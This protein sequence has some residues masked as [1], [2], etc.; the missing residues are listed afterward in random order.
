MSTKI[1][2]IGGTGRIGSKVVERLRGH[3]YEVVAAAPQTGVNTV[4][5]EGVAEA[6]KGAAVVVDVSNSPSFEENEALAF[7]PGLDGEP[8]SPGSEGRVGHLVALSVVG[9]DRMQHIP[10]FRAKIVVE[11]MLKVAPIPYSIVRATQF[12]EFVDMIAD[13]ATEG[14]VVRLPPVAF[15]PMAAEDVAK[16]V[17][18][19]AAGP[20]VNGVVETAGPERFRLDEL[21]RSCLAFRNDRREVIADPTASYYGGAVQEGTLVPAGDAYLGSIRFEEWLNPVGVRG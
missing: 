2:V 18:R 6:L 15:Q 7:F 20:P 17:A 19:T 10:Y 14:N 8:G 16:M 4:T 5:G 3:G 13:S 21:V 1:V 12:F 9:I 11:Q